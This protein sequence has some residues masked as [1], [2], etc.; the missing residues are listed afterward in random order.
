MQHEKLTD[1][2]KLEELLSKFIAPGVI[3]SVN[4]VK[5]SACATPA[6]ETIEFRQTDGEFVVIAGAYG[7]LLARVKPTPKMVRRVKISGKLAGELV[8]RVFLPED[9][10]YKFENALEDVTK[11]DIEVP[12]AQAN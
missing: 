5:E 11:E 2:K 7:S 6:I 9:S 8:S 4:T 12:D 10:T 3:L 1:A